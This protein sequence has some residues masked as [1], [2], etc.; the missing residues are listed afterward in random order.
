MSSI[1]QFEAHL[2][3]ERLGASTRRG[4]A[5]DV[6][7]FL[8][9]LAGRTETELVPR[10]VTLTQ[11]KKY[12]EAKQAEGRSSRMLNRSLSSLRRYFGWLEAQGP[13]VTTASALPRLRVDSSK[14]LESLSSTEVSGLARAARSTGFPRDRLRNEALVLVLV[15][16][17]IRLGEAVS[18]RWSDLSIRARTGVVEIALSHGSGSR[19]IPLD[20][21]AR[22]TLSR[23]KEDG[24]RRSY[25]F[26]SSRGGSMSP[27]TVE[28]LMRELAAR[29]RLKRVVTTKLLR[30]TFARTYL[31]QHPGD[32]VGLAS[33]LGLSV[34]SAATYIHPTPDSLSAKIEE[35]PRRIDGSK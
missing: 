17:G 32:L 28:H 23:L 9:W 11:V 29:A 33:L 19:S 35:F 4:Y 16:T 25:V 24:K 30:H 2:L 3:T 7:R 1:S 8:V 34:G 31:E 6:T 20:R 21:V 26:L 27:R 5:E 15:H 18:M 13:V 12:V 10:E 22:A 14:P